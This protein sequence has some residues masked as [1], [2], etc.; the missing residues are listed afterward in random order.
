MEDSVSIYALLN[1]IAECGRLKQVALTG[2][3]LTETVPLTLIV[4][5]QVALTASRQKVDL[6]LL[7]VYRIF[8]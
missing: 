3:K 7:D 8:Q 5:Q 6:K 4:S 2:R 1:A